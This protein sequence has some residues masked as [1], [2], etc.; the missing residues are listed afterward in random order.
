[1]IS[2][3]VSRGDLGQVAPHYAPLASPSLTKTSTPLFNV[4]GESSLST[5]GTNTPQFLIK[6]GSECHEGETFKS[7]RQ[8]RRVEFSNKV[9]LPMK[10]EMKLNLPLVMT[11]KIEEIIIEIKQAKDTLINLNNTKK[12][13]EINLELNENTPLE[14]VKKQS[15]IV[16]NTL[17]QVRN[18]NPT[19]PIISELNEKKEKLDSLKKIHDE[20][21]SCEKL[22]NKLEYLLEN[23]NQFEASKKSGLLIEKFLEFMDLIND[24]ILMFNQPDGV[25]KKLNVLEKLN[26][27]RTLFSQS[28]QLIFERLV[29]NNLNNSSRNE[30]FIYLAKRHPL[31]F[32]ILKRIFGIIFSLCSADSKFNM[33]FL[34][35]SQ[36]ILDKMK[37]NDFFKNEKNILNE[38][39]I[40]KDKKNFYNFIEKLNSF[41]LETPWF[42]NS[43]A[44]E[45]EVVP[46]GKD[47]RITTR[48]SE[49]SKLFVE[50]QANGN[51]LLFQYQGKDDSGALTPISVTENLPSTGWFSSLIGQ[52]KSFSQLV[53]ILLQEKEEK[54]LLRNVYMQAKEL[55]KYAPS[56]EDYFGWKHETEIVRHISLFNLLE[57]FIN[58][59]H[60]KINSNL[61]NN[62]LGSVLFSN[63]NGKEIV[64]PQLNMESLIQEALSTGTFSFFPVMATTITTTTE[65]TTATTTTVSQ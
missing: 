28:L 54:G 49:I 29:D 47:V 17:F 26:T 41:M 63:R 50:K 10:N 24:A 5:P 1:M 23:Y 36:F 62:P 51:Y 25:F 48:G 46:S 12:K 20:I 53:S 39:Q 43:R 32:E 18:K 2:N 40:E 65:T 44:F 61:Y 15:R 55:K 35:E 11:K 56:V 4:S 33:L 64:I 6:N 42:Y 3:V 58:S 14:D 16:I 60:P 31:E 7:A 19:N 38:L 13:L 52:Q 8:Q 30:S 27:L 34:F 21:L 45:I 59:E 22:S 57:R 37:Y 9:L